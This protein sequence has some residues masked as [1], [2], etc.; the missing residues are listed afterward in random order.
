MDEEPLPE[1]KLN[2]IGSQ[3]IPKKLKKVI[4]VRESSSIIDSI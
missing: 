2:L 1:S 3:V 4:K